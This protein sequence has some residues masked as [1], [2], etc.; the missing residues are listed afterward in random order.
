MPVRLDFPF[1]IQ[2]GHVLSQTDED[3]IIRDKIIQVLFTTPGERVNLP[4]F[5]CGLLQFVFEPNNDILAATLEFTIMDA[6]SRWMKEDIMVE[7]VNLESSPDGTISAEI[8]YKK[9][10]D[11][12]R[13]GIRIEY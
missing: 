9:K 1:R 7:T 5:S 4:E 2:D 12:S 11:S 13:Q 8:I 6:L 10:Q 3:D